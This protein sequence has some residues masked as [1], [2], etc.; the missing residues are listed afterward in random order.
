[1]EY[2]IDIDHSKRIISGWASSSSFSVTKLPVVKL[3]NAK[4][5]SFQIAL[6]QQ[7]PDVYSLGLSKA[8]NCGFMVDCNLN[9]LIDGDLIRIVISFGCSPSVGRTFMLGDHDIH[10]SNFLR[11]ELARDDF[12]I[13]KISTQDLMASGSDLFNLKKLLIRLRRAKRG[14]GWR[15]SFSGFEYHHFNDDYDYFKRIVI[16]GRYVLFDL[17]PI[18]YIWSIIDT[19]AD[20]GGVENQAAWLC[21]STNLASERMAQSLKLIEQSKRLDNIV[22]DK[23]IGYWGG[24]YSNKLNADDSLDTIITRNIECLKSYPIAYSYY[25]KIMLSMN[26]STDSVWS[27][28]ICNSLYFSEAWKFYKNKFLS[29]NIIDTQEINKKESFNYI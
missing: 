10:I 22:L 13:M 26:D 4:G 25:R 21:L 6:D 11:Y 5:K 3:F 2:S 15:G 28:N 14:L 7:R 8:I 12:S 1:M 17:L 23:Q 24:M 27:R 9:N 29:E 16:E 19:L 18:R 20:F